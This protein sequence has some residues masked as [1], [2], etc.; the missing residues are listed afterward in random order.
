MRHIRVNFNEDL[1]HTCVQCDTEDVRLTT[2]LQEKFIQVICMNCRHVRNVGFDTK[3]F[4]N[5]LY[6][7][8]EDC[9]VVD[10]CEIPF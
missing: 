6:I 2:N 9:E 4:D 10:L 7:F 8:P 3:M 5:D 1:L